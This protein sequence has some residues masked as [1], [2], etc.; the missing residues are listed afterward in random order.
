MTAP[1]EVRAEVRGPAAFITI[2]RPASRNAMTWTMYEQL[3]A[4]LARLESDRA[5]RLVVLRGAGGTFVA[6]T[7]IA[8]LR[9]FSSGEEGLAYEHRL[10]AV[11]GQLESLTIPTLAVVEGDATGAGLVLAAVCDLRVCTPDAR[12]GA[13][14]ARTVG[15]TLSTANV[16][17]LVSHLGPSRVKSVLMAAAMLD[18]EDAR[19]AGFVLA[20]IAPGELDGRLEA[21]VRH[22][23]H[24]APITLRTTKEAVRR[25]RV[26][27]NGPEDTDLMRFGVRKPRLRRGREGVS[28]KARTALGRQVTAD[29]TVTSGLR[30]A[31]RG[32]RCW[33]CGF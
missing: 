24:L 27:L 6:G 12:F 11:V 3:S 14:I 25:A 10:E 30:P 19:N 22:V 23:T 13:P 32:P 16:T 26:A 7:D 20:V 29:S 8:Q 33:A 21:L 9:D 18:A 31:A 1:G 28:R 5:L 17:R 15:N 4:V 2:D